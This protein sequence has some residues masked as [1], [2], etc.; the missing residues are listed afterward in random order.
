MAVNQLMKR[1]GTLTLAVVVCF[2]DVTSHAKVTNLDS[3]IFGHHT[4]ASCQITVYK[5]LASQVGHPISNLH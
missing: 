3:E 2:I 5:L 1:S 4:V